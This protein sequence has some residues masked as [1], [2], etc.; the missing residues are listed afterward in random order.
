VNKLNLLDFILIIILIAG[1]AVGFK[2]GFTKELVCFLK[3][4]LAFVLAFLLKNPVST[5]MYQNLPFFSFGGLFKGV[6]VINI[7]LYELIAFL[8][9][10]FILMFLF[11]ILLLA[12]SIFEKI[13]NVTVVLSIPSKILGMIVG[14]VHYFLIIFICLFVLNLPV[15]NIEI[16]SSSK[17]KTPI[18]NKTPFLSNLALKT[19]K[20]I[21]EFEELKE[22]YKVSNNTNE[23]NLKTIDLFLKYDVITV[24]SV[25]ILNKR[26]KLKIDLLESVVEKY[27]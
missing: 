7:L 10:L 17:F 8:L 23:F 22:E 25:D 14:L 20:T 1:L 3:F 4:A 27:R 13:L 2:R 19:T 26:G 16:V 24:K 9:I 18:L 6:T 21:A 15:F 5:L 11:R 12:T